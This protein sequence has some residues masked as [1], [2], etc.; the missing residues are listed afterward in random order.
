MSKLLDY[1]ANLWIFGALLF[2]VLSFV[3]GIVQSFRGKTD[4]HIPAF[5]L[6][7]IVWLWVIMALAG[8]VTAIVGMVVLPVVRWFMH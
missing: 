7:P 6:A 4:F 3:V 1:S 5:V 8:I 2:T